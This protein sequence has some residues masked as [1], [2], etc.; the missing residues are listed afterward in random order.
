MNQSINQPTNEKA[1]NQPISETNQKTN[2]QTFDIRNI[3]KWPFQDN[4]NKSKLI[5]IKTS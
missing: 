2:Q 5:E 4:K 3:L 1:N